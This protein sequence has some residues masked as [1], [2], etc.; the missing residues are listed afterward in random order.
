M[1]KFGGL[2]YSID[3]RE[4]LLKLKRVEIIPKGNQLDLNTV[5]TSEEDVRH[6]TIRE[7]AV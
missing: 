1:L 4:M 6:A 3:S 5:L 7:R 2:S